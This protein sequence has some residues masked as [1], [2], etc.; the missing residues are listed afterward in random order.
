MTLNRSSWKLLQPSNTR[1][2]YTPK[3]KETVME[4]TIREL[5]ARI[6]NDAITIAQ[7]AAVIIQLQEALREAQTAPAEDA[8]T[9]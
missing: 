4:Q 8:E 7:Q 3:R 5:A 1:P 9:P 6:A 2:H